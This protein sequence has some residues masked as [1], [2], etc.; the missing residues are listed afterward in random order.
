MDGSL[1]PLFIN[2][3]LKC[4]YIL[5]LQLDMICIMVIAVGWNILDFIVVIFGFLELSSS[6]GN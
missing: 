5:N 3:C 1:G 6:F 2:I 4:S